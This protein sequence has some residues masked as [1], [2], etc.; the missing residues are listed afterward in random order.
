MKKQYLNQNLLDFVEDPGLIVVNRVILYGLMHHAL[1]ESIYNLYVIEVDDYTAGRAAW[2]LCNLI[3]LDSDLD[4]F[5]AGKE[6]EL[7]MVPGLRNAV[8]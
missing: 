6:G 8:K 2:D 3:C 5:E 1:F 4:V 7:E